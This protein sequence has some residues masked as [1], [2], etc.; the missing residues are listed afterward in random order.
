MFTQNLKE[1][2]PF[3]TDYFEVGLKNP[4]RNIAHS[5]LF[6]G[7]DISAQYE[8]AM[9][10]ARLLNCKEFQNE[11]CKC[12]NCNW[13]RDGKHPA[14]LIVSKIDNKPSD[15]ESKTV[16]SVKQSRMVKNS[17]L[18]T[19]EYHR[20]F[21]FCDAKMEGEKWTPLGLNETNFQEETANS[22]LKIIEEP[23]E[24]TTFF[25]LARDK[26]DLIETIISRSQS[27]F[28][29]S[30]ET[31]NKDYKAIEEIFSDYL[32]FERKNSLDFAQNLF[33]LSKENGSEKTLTEIQNYLL[34]LLKSNLNNNTAK[35]KILSDIKK[36]E[37]A[38][39]MINNHINPQLAFEDMCLNFTN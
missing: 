30:F 26:N 36:V 22:L 37:L 2:Y 8:L 24:N 5:I 28:V 17:L 39:K 3:L 6:Y 21:I 25:F 11:E 34:D 12:L 29:P 23:P 38:K 9:E 4:E 35:N 14:V 19:S 18:N 16:I 33:L 7:Q 15:D 10:I 1:K 31:E 32:T 13:I 27:F 20:V